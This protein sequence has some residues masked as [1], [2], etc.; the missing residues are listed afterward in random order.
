MLNT[1]ARGARPINVPGEERRSPRIATALPA[2]LSTGQRNHPA[3]LIDVAPEGAKIECGDVLAIGTPLIF[4]SG[5]IS[6]PAY[7]IWGEDGRYGL[8][9][10]SPLEEAEVAEQVRRADAML[11]YGLKSC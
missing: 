4:K 10:D 3:L 9:F 7:V 11:A 2:M 8:E 6:V 5:A 1:G